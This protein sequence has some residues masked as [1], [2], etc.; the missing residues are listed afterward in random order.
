[1]TDK[2]VKEEINRRAERHLPYLNSTSPCQVCLG[3]GRVGDI[4]PRQ[5][6]VIVNGGAVQSVH[7]LPIGLRLLVM[8]YDTPRVGGSDVEIKTNQLGR[9]V[10]TVFEENNG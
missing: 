6:V 9:Y 8:D 5:V 7:G 2:E 4:E 10:E 3:N 1:M